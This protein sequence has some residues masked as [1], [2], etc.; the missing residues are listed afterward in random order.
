MKVPFDT[1][2]EESRFWI[3]QTNRCIEKKILNNN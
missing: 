2:P 1:L 3:Y